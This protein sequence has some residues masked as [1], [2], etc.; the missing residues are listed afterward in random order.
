MYEIEYMWTKELII[1]TG[2]NIATVKLSNWKPQ[3]MLYHSLSIHLNKFIVTGILL[4]PTSKKANI[5]K[6]V[7]IITLKQ[8]IN[9]APLTPAFLPKKPAT[10]DPNKGKIMILKYIIYIL[11]LYFLFV[12]P[13]YSHIE[14]DY[15]LS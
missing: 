13:Q 8:V 9:C 7:V 1:N 2:I 11:Y 15:T 5:A 14:T 4:K 12:L 10:I 3:R 6:P